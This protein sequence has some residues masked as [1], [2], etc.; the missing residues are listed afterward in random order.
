MTQEGLITEKK[1]LEENKNISESFNKK[2]KIIL[3]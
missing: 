3:G 1:C 2:G